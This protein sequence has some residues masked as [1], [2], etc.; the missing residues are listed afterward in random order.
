[1]SHLFFYVSKVKSL[2]AVSLLL[3]FLFLA[4]CREKEPE[5]EGAPLPVITLLKE[6]ANVS[7][8]YLGSI[9]GIVNV[10]IRPQVEGILEEIYVDEGEFVKK[11]QLLFK[12]NDQPYQEALKNAMAKIGRAS[13]RERGKSSR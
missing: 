7:Y 12:I 4:S 5:D 3:S 6:T 11:G 13:C 1:M 2:G 10:E 9:E 8:P